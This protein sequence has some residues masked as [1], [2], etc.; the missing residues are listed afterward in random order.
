M[1]NN[2]IRARIGAQGWKLLELPIR[3]SGPTGQVARWKITAVKGERSI[4]VGGTTI[5]EALRNIGVSLG[6]IP[7]R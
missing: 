7:K 6:V 1:D 2:A 5:D 3:K 4:E